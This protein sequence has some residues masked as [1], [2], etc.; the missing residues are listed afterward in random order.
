MSGWERHGY[1]TPGRTT[2]HR[3]SRLLAGIAIEKLDTSPILANRIHAGT[4][5]LSTSAEAQERIG[6]I[7]RIPM[8]RPLSGVITPGILAED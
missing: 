7:Q 2:I 3:N 6:S 1:H 8:Y 5:G 4:P